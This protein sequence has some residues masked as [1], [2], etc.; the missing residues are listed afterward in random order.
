MRKR[1]SR[2]YRHQIPN[3]AHILIKLP[4]PIN[5][6]IGALLLNNNESFNVLFL[7]YG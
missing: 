3:C 4:D 1:K 2:K 7:I 5:K 6:T